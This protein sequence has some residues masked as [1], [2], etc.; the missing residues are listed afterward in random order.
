MNSLMSRKNFIKVEEDFTCVNCGLRV[1]GSGYTNHCPECLWSLH[2]DRSTPGD[3][4]SG[5]GGAMEPI[6]VEKRNGEW[7]ILHKCNEC[8][9][10]I[11]NKVSKNDNQELIVELSRN[12]VSV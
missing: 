11:F 8:G 4:M 6:G 5:C 1:K 7:R 9:K 12:P 2:V 3:R 10:T